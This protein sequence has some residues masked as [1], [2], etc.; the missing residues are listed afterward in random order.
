MKEKV[1][2]KKYLLENDLINSEESFSRIIDCDGSECMFDILDY[3]T[4]LRDWF[5]S[6]NIYG[7]KIYDGLDEI[8]IKKIEKFFYPHF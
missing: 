5:V 3:N 4:E 2:I 1:L 8:G 6:Q 7:V